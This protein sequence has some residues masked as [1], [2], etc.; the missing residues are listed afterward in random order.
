MTDAHNAVVLRYSPYN[1]A[2]TDIVRSGSLGELV[3]VVH[4]EPVGHWHF[5]HSYVRGN[6]SKKQDSSSVLMTKSCQ[7]VSYFSTLSPHDVVASIVISI[8]FVIG[9]HPLDLCVCRLSDLYTIFDG[10][11]NPWQLDTL[12]DVLIVRPSGIALT[13]QRKVA[14]LSITLH[15]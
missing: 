1:Q 4:V 14:S 3:N 2:I 8:F 6:W 12:P 7:C 11:G 5:A 15:Q 13:V 10:Q 9:C